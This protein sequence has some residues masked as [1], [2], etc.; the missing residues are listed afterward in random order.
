[1]GILKGSVFNPE[2]SDSRNQ[3]DLVAR[4]Y[5][6]LEQCVFGSR[7]T[8][9]RLAFFDAVV[10]R[11]RVLLAGEGNGRFL[12]LLLARKNKGCIKV[13]E[14]SAVMICLAKARIRKVG[15]ASCDLEFI[16]SDV[17]EYDAANKFDCVV[18]HFLLDA[19]NPP[20]QQSVI[21]KITELTTPSGTWINVDFLPARTLRGGIL[22]WT[23]YAF[24]R[25]VSK[26]EASHCCDASAAAAAAGWTVVETISYLGGLVVATHWK[27]APVPPPE[28][29]C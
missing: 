4:F 29:L 9:A 21:R 8:R 20:G 13:V 27:K 3:F 17:R 5:P 1:M 7:L 26:L 23:Q 16:E 19:F 10:Q 11:E 24:F 25:L 22:M 14:K 15:K 18:T 28:E 6:A 2:S 12:T